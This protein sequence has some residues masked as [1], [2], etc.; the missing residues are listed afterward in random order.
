M[1]ISTEGNNYVTKLDKRPINIWPI[2]DFFFLPKEY[3]Y[4]RLFRFKLLR[5]EYFRRNKYPW[6]TSQGPFE[7]RRVPFPR[8]TYVITLTS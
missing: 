5:V 7:S 1:R 4:F 2:K 6:E 8:R 3:Q